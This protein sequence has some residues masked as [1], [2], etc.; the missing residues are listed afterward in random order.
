MWEN[1]TSYTSCFSYSP[2]AD[3]P[4][5]R[6]N[7]DSTSG[8]TTWEKLTIRIR[9]SWGLQNTFITMKYAFMEH[10][11][12]HG[13]GTFTAWLTYCVF[14]TCN[15][16]KISVGT[17]RNVINL[18]CIVKLIEFQWQRSQVITRQAMRCKC[19]LNLN[20]S[21]LMTRSTTRFSRSQQ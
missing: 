1:C 12:W 2:N 14:R 8:S 19:L 13:M 5:A 9:L 20:E 4:S 16:A 15:S 21:C 7:P 18:K 11:R 10:G 6:A 17:S 3:M